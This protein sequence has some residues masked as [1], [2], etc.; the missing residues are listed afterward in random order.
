MVIMEL[1][2]I[3]KSQPGVRVET[4]AATHFLL[5][6]FVFDD[7]EVVVLKVSLFAQLS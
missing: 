7:P 3:N 4:G 2:C 1:S 6:G 5:S